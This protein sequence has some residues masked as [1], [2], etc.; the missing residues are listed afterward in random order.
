MISIETKYNMYQSINNPTRTSATSKSLIDLIFTTLAA[1]IILENGTMN[2]IISDHLL[3][4]IVKK[5]KREKHT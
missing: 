1:E 2:V 5:K 3:V 4:Y